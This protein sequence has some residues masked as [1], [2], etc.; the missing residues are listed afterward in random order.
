M[1][2][3]GTSG[4]T[5][6]NTDKAKFTVIFKHVPVEPTDTE[7]QA[8]HIIEYLTIC[9]LAVHLTTLSVTKL[10]SAE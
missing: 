4:R 8:R 10:Y 6:L 3:T 2:I 5:E 7:V 1:I 9:L